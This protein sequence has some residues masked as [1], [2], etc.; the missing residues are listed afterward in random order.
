MTE[1]ELLSMLGPRIASLRWNAGLSQAALAKRLKISPSTV[2]MYEQG[3]RIPPNDILV[4]LSAE[5]NVT[6]DFLLAGN[7]HS[8]QDLA[9]LY[10]ILISSQVRKIFSPQNTLDENCSRQYL[11]VQIALMLTDGQ[12]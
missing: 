10:Q 8:Q 2:G 3:R 6:V 7:C 12:P 1:S 5:F 9:T 11:T 4:A